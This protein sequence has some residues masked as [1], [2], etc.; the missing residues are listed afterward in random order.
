MSDGWHH[1]EEATTKQQ[2]EGREDMSEKIIPPAETS[3]KYISW[4][5]KEMNESLKKLTALFEAF[6]VSLRHNAEK[7]TSSFK[8]DEIP[9]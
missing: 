3:L 7:P 2:L 5:V 9:F 8:Q 1:F 4:S 6:S